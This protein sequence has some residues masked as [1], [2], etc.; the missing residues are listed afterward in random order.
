MQVPFW[1]I[2]RKVG[3]VDAKAPQEGRREESLDTERQS[4][5]VLHPG[6]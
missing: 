2:I 4:K 3:S 1:P 6:T 5:G